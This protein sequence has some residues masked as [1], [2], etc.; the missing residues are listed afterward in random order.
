[1]AP[2]G[3]RGCRDEGG[4]VQGARSPATRWRFAFDQLVITVDATGQ[5]FHAHFVAQAVPPLFAG[6]VHGRFMAQSSS[7][8]AAVC[9]PRQ[10][11]TR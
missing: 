10:A 4:G 3:P 8:L 1:M 9:A 11:S 5:T 2:D 6:G 7:F